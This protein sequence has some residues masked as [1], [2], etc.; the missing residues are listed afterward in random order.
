MSNK[1]RRLQKQCFPVNYFVITFEKLEKTKKRN[2]FKTRRE[3]SGSPPSKDVK[4]EET[5]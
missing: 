4:N 3:G 2:E 1:L 5:R